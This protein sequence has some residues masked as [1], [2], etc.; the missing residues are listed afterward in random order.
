MAFS[1]AGG[2]I[3]DIK[4]L[5]DCAMFG[6]MDIGEWALRSLIHLAT[7]MASPASTTAD[8]ELTSELLGDVLRWRI[9][10]IIRPSV[11]SWRIV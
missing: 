3:E 6:D 7:W 1:D 4:K 2:S 10:T 5:T 8:V 11:G 9:P